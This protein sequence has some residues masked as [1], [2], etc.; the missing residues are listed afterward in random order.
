MCWGVVISCCEEVDA[1]EAC[2][3]KKAKWWACKCLRNSHLLS[4]ILCIFPSFFRH[5]DL[6]FCMRRVCHFSL[7]WERLFKARSYRMLMW[8]ISQV[9]TSPSAPVSVSHDLS[10]SHFCFLHLLHLFLCSPSVIRGCQGTSVW[11]RERTRTTD[12]NTV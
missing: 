1:F 4:L 3:T 10:V 11:D 9:L 12:R 8:T 5:T 2:F 7:P 6:F